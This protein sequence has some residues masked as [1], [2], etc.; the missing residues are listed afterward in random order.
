MHRPLAR[1]LICLL[2]GPSKPA[3][4]IAKR[5]LP[6][7]IFSPNGRRCISITRTSCS[8]PRSTTTKPAGLLADL[9]FGPFPDSAGAATGAA[10]IATRT[11]SAFA[12]PR[13]DERERDCRD[14]PT[15]TDVRGSLTRVRL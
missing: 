8:G 13:H 2:E 9:L 6:R 4:V 11:L 5:R 14:T 7:S 12:L 1:K 10:W 15:P 3:T